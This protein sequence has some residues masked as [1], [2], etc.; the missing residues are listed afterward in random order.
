VRVALGQTEAAAALGVCLNTFRSHI[1][2]ESA[3][4]VESI[5]RE[6]TKPVA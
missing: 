4:L 5:E 1:A 3:Q 6:L 2:P